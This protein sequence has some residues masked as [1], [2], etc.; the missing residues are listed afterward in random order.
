MVSM[1]SDGEA[2]DLTG[3]HVIFPDEGF[4]WQQES[5]TGHTGI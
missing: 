2:N 3:R 4:H 5:L 1:S